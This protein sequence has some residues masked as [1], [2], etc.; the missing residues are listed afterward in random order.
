MP[1]SY[2]PYRQAELDQRAAEEEIKAQRRLNAQQAKQAA[3]ASEAM[4]KEDR[5]AELS[6]QELDMR[7]QG[8]IPVTTADGNLHPDPLW[9]Q[10]QAEKAAK[11]AQ[12]QQAAKIADQFARE[13]RKSFV[14]KVT[15]LPTA[16]ESDEQLAA[17]KQAK[18]DAARK[19]AIN[20]RITALETAASDPA[21]KR[22]PTSARDKLAKQI[23]KTRQEALFGLQSTL[24]EQAK[25]VS[26]GDDY[27]PFN[28]APT[29]EA[30]AA[31]ERLTR[32]SQPGAD[33]TEE[34]LALLEANDATKPQAQKLRN[35][36]ALLAKDDEAAKFHDTQAA[37]VFDLKLR[38][39]DPA[40]WA[41]KVK[42]RRAAMTPEQLKTD[43]ESSSADLQARSQELQAKV[44]PIQ[45]RRALSQQKLDTLS[46]QAAQRR[47]RG[48]MASEIVTFTRPDGSTEDWPADLAATYERESAMAQQAETQ[49]AATLEQLQALQADLQA[50]AAL[51]DEGTATLGAKA[52][53]QQQTA[54]SQFSNR[55]R[56][57]PGME[58]AAGEIEALQSDAETRKAVLDDMYP[59]GAPPEAI[60][61]LNADVQAKAEQAIAT[62]QARLNA[63]TA[64][65]GGIQAQ[66]KANPD[67]NATAGD[68]FIATRKKLAQDAGITEAEAKRLLDDAGQLDWDQVTADEINQGLVAE[69]W[70]SGKNMS[71]AEDSRKTRLLSN[72]AVIVHPNITDEKGY[73]AAVSQSGATPDAQAEAL[74]RYPAIRAQQ[75]KQTLETIQEVQSVLGPDSLT[76]WEDYADWKKKKPTDVDEAEWALRWSEAN[77]AKNTGILGTLLS[78]TKQFIGNIAAGGND[79]RQQASG[80]LAGI[81]GSETLMQDAQWAGRKAEAQGSRLALGGHTSDNFLTKGV[82]DQLPRLSTSLVPAVGGAKAAQAGIRLFAGTKLG[83]RFLPSLAAALETAATPAQAVKAVSTL[84]RAGLGGAAAAGA[85]Q[86][87]GAQ[88]AD[89]YGTLRKENPEL[90]HATA[91]RQAQM[92]AIASGLATALLTVGFGST[93][94]SRLITRPAEAKAAAAKVFTS[95]LQ[96]MGFAAE[97]FVSGGIMET[98]E[99]SLDEGISQVAAALGKG[100]P[101]QQAVG[102]FLR[103]LPEMAVATMIMGGAGEGISSFKESSLQGTAASRA[104]LPETT[105][106][107]ESA[108]DNLQLPGV[109]DAT[110]EQMQ[111]RA[112][113]ALSLAQGG[114]LLEVEESDLNAAGWTRD[115]DTFKPLKGYTGPAVLDIDKGGR[116]IIKDAY[117]Q[118]LRDNGLDAVANAIPGTETQTRNRYA[119][120]GTKNEQP[121]TS[122]APAGPQQ[123]QPS[124]AP[125]TPTPVSGNANPGPV[126][127][128]AINGAQ[129]PP[130]GNPAA[131]SG[132]P[133]T[134]SPTT[135]NNSQP[136]QTS[137][138]DPTAV[139]TLEKSLA[140]WL[141]DRYMPDKEAA[142]AAKALAAHPQIAGKSFDDFNKLAGPQ[143]D[144][145]FAALGITGSKAKTKAAT[146]PL[147]F[148]PTVNNSQPPSTAKPSTSPPTAA[149]FAKAQAAFDDSIEGTPERAAAEA[150]LKYLREKQLVADLAPVKAAVQ[151]KELDEEQATQAAAAALRATSQPVT[152]SALRSALELALGWNTNRANVASHNHLG[153]K[154]QS[155]TPLASGER[156]D[157][158]NRPQATG[159]PDPS[160]ARMGPDL[161]LK[162][163]SALRKNSAYSRAKLL[164]L[165]RIKD[166]AK[167]AWARAAFAALEDSIQRH[168]ALYD[169][170]A[171]GPAAIRRLNGAMTAVAEIDGRITRLLDLNAIVANFDY[172]ANP[173][174]A[175]RAT[176]IEEDI[177]ATV[178]R[179]ART[180]PE[181]YG[182]EAIRKQWRSLPQNLRELVWKAYDYGRTTLPAKLTAQQ[183]YHMQNE[184]LRMLVQ[185]QAFAQAITE[186]VDTPTT[187]VQWITDLLRDLS[188]TLRE[189]M[190]QVDAPLRAELQGMVDQIAAQLRIF[191]KE[192][193]GTADRLATLDYLRDPAGI[194]LQAM[195][196]GVLFDHLAKTDPSLTPEA[197]ARAFDL[198][199]PELQSLAYRAYRA[200][201]N[202]APGTKNKEPKSALLRHLLTA[203]AGD[204]SVSREVQSALLSKSPSLQVSKSAPLLSRFLAR[205]TQRTEAPP[206]DLLTLLKQQPQKARQTLASLNAR[207]IRAAADL[208]GAQFVQSMPG[209]V[210]DVFTA[211]PPERHA[212]MIAALRQAELRAQAE[213]KLLFQSAIPGTVLA[214]LRR[215]AYAAGEAN[216]DLTQSPNA[217]PEAAAELRKRLMQ[218]EIDARRQ[219]ESGL[220]PT[221]QD[222]SDPSDP[223][224][225]TPTR[226]D[227]MAAAL[228][229]RERLA[230][231]NR[232]P[233]ARDALK[234]RLRAQQYTAELL[235]ARSTQELNSLEQQRRLSPQVRRLIDAML[236]AARGDF[237]PSNRKMGSNYKLAGETT[238]MDLAALGIRIQPQTGR[239]YTADPVNTSAYVEQGHVILRQEALDDL[240]VLAPITRQL[241]RMTERQVRQVFDLPVTG[242]EPVTE[243]N[244]AEEEQPE[245]PP[246]ETPPSTPVNAPSEPQPPSTTPDL[247]VSQPSTTVNAA[248]QPQPPSTPKARIPLGGKLSL[249]AQFASQDDLDA[250][251]YQ[252]DRES[253]LRETTSTTDRRKAT[254]RIQS[255]RARLID[256]T[257]ASKE[258]I[259]QRLA[260]YHRAV[261]DSAKKADPVEV[262]RPTPFHAFAGGVS[263]TSDATL[264]APTGGDIISGMKA[265]GIRRLGPPDKSDGWAW[266]RE[267][268]ADASKSKIKAREAA[269][270][271][272]A[273]DLTDSKAL[274]AWVDTHIVK[275]DGGRSIDEAAT[276]LNESEE[277]QFQVASGEE[278]G[279][280]ILDAIAAR[281][282]AR[283]ATPDPMVQAEKQA[284]Q[285]GGDFR[286]VAEGAT[287]QPFTGSTLAARVQT[288]DE[289]QIG[290]EWLTVT[291]VDTEEG[292]VSLDSDRYG[293]QSIDPDQTVHLRAIGDEVLNSQPSPTVNNGQ[294]PSTSPSARLS[295]DTIATLQNALPPGQRD[296]FRP[297][298]IEQTLTPLPQEKLATPA[299]TAALDA[300]LRASV[301]AG[302]A[303]DSSAPQ[304]ADAD[305]NDELGENADDYLDGEA[306]N[307]ALRTT[308]DQRRQSL[309]GASVKLGEKSVRTGEPVTFRF[310]HNLQSATKIWGKPTKDSQFD[311]GFEPSGRYVSETTDPDYLLKTFPGQYAAGELTFEN[312]IVIDGGEYGSDTS[313]KRRLSTLYGGTRGKRLSQALLTDGYDG[314]ITVSNG[315]TSEILDLTTFDAS[316]ALYASNRLAPNGKPSN[317]TEAQWHQVRTPQFKKWFGDWEIAA[318]NP[319]RN[320]ST[321]SEA[322]E[323]VKEFQGKPLSNRKTG[324][325]ATLSRNALDKILSA[326]AVGK[327]ETAQT[328]SL[329][330]ANADV[331]FESAILGWSKPD[332]NADPNI[333][334]IHRFFA[335]MITNGK[336]M[337]VKMTVKETSQ[338]GR[339][340]PL[341]TVEAVEFNEMSPAAIWVGEIANA[342]GIDPRT[343]R[344]VGDLE[345]LTQE[346]QDFNPDSVSKVVDENGEPMVVYHGTHRDFDQFKGNAYYFSANPKTASTFA[347]IRS[348]GRG[349]ENVMPVFLSLKSPVQEDMDGASWQEMEDRL[350]RAFSKGDSAIFENV[351]DS[352]GDETQYIAFDPTQIKSAVANNGDFDGTNPSILF[353]SKR[354]KDALP[355]PRLTALHN[356]SIENL[357]FA[358]RMGGL[359]VPSVAV[360]PQGQGISGF[361][362][363]TLIGTR[364]LVDPAKEPVFDSDAYSPRFPDAEYSKAK[365]KEAQA[366]VD[367]LRPFATRFDD[368]SLIHT[369]WDNAVNRPN[370]ADS[371]TKLLRSDAAKASFLASKGV[372]IEPVLMPKPLS[373]S[374]VTQ[375]SF[376]KYR[377]N[378]AL[379]TQVS[380]NDKQALDAIG[381]DIKAAINEELAAKHQ[382]TDKPTRDFIRKSYLETYLDED[383]G[384]SNYGRLQ[385]VEISLQ[386]VGKQ[387]VDSTATGERITAAMAGQDAEFKQWADD[388]ILPLHPAPHLTLKGRKAPYTL[389]NIVSAM[390][391]RVRGREDGMTMGEGKA[392]AQI[393]KKFNDL[394][395]MRAAAAVQ[396]LPKEQVSADREK[397]QKLLETY[398]NT[399]AEFTTLT[400][401]RGAKDYFAAFDAAMAALVTWAKGR[402]DVATLESAL[403][404]EGFKDVPKDA[405]ALGQQA[406]EAWL[407]APVPYFEAKPQRAVA[408]SEFA[409]AVIPESAPSGVKTI[410]DKHGILHRAYSG[411]SANQASAAAQFAQDLNDQ[412]LG[413]LFASGRTPIL[414]ASRD[415]TA[416]RTAKD[417]WTA[418]GFPRS[419]ADD[420]VD[421]FY[422][423]AAFADIPSNAVLL[424]MPS[425]SGRNIL[426]DVLAQRIA[427]QQGATV[428]TGRV[429]SATARTEAKKKTSFWAKMDDP[430]GYIPGPDFDALRRATGPI[431]LV[432]DVHN[433]GESWMAM[434]R[435]L[436]DNGIP[437]AGVATLTATELRVTSPRDIERLSEKIATL[438][439]TPLDKT[440]ELVY[441]LFHDSY[442]QWFN[443]AERIATGDAGQ[444]VRLL[445]AARA[446]A[447]ERATQRN[448]EAANEGRVQ[449]QGNQDALAP[450]YE[451]L[452]LFASSRLKESA[453][454]GYLDLPNV[455]VPAAK[456]PTAKRAI[457]AAAASTDPYDLPASRGDVDRSRRLDTLRERAQRTWRGLMNQDVDALKEAF[458]EKD[459]FSTLLHDFI[460]R[461]IPRFDIR[462]AIIEG[463]A[464]FAAFN[465]AV[466]TPYFESLK[467]AI[468]DAANQVVHSQIVHVGGLNEAIADPKVIAGIIA[469]ARMLNPKSKLTGWMIAHNHPSGDP[470]PSDAD[471]RVTRRLLAMGENIGLPLIDHVVTNGERYFSFRESGL[472]FSSIDDSIAQ[473]PTRSSKPK[474]PA[475]PTPTAPFQDNLA[476]YE[477]LPSGSLKTSI[478]LNAPDKTRPYLQTLRT[479]DPDHYHVLY[480]DTRLALRAVERIPTSVTLPQLFQRIVLGSAREGGHAF[481]L[482]FPATLETPNVVQEDQ[483]NAAAPSPQQRQIVRRLRELSQSIGLVFADAMTHSQERHFSFSEYGLMEEPGALASGPRRAR[484]SMTFDPPFKAPFGDILSYSWASKPIGGMQSQRVSDWNNAITN[485]QTGRDIVHLFKVRKPDGIHTVSLETALGLLSSQDRNRL[486]SIIRSKQ[487][488]MED[489]NAG[490]MRLFA[491]S[492]LPIAPQLD[493]RYTNTDGQDS[494]E[495]R[496]NS[497]PLADNLS[498]GSSPDRSDA[499]RLPS[500][501]VQL[502]AW[503]KT[504]GWLIDTDDLDQRLGL[505]TEVRAGDEHDVW[506]DELTNRAVKLTRHTLGQPVFIA[507]SPI[508]YIVNLKQQNA[509]FGTD[510][511]F[512]G[513]VSDEGIPRIV[514]SMPW[515]YGTPVTQQAK[516]KY[517]KALGF[518][519][520]GDDTFYSMGRD[521]LVTDARAANVVERP[522]GTIQPIDIQIRAVSP[523]QAEMWENRVNARASLPAA[524]RV[525]QAA[526]QTNANPSDAQKAAGNYQK[527]KINL[528]GLRLSIENPAGSVR[529]GTDA[530][531]KP[532]SVTLPH[533]YGYILGT[534][535]K[536][537][538]H[539]DIFLGPNPDSQQVLIINQRKSGNGHFDEHKVMLGFNTPAEAA[540]GYMA[541]YT[542]GWKGLGSAIPTTIPVF[543][544]WLEKHD[545]TQP[546]TKEQID[547]LADALPASKRQPDTSITNPSDA[548]FV[549]ARVAEW[550][551]AVAKA[552]AA[553]L[554]AIDLRKKRE[555]ADE[556]FFKAPPEEK[557]ARRTEAMQLSDAEWEAKK[558]ADRFP[559]S[560]QGL[561]IRFGI[562]PASGRSQNF[563]TST[564]DR[565]RY[566]K[567]I[568]TFPVTWENGRWQ[569]AT[570]Y[571][572]AP[573]LDALIGRHDRHIYLVTGTVVDEGEDN[574]PVLGSDYRVLKE[575]TPTEILPPDYGNDPTE[576]D[577]SD[578]AQNWQTLFAAPRVETAARALDK[579]VTG[580][581][582]AIPTTIPVFKQ[583]LE[584][585]DT[586]QPATKEQIDK[587]S[588]SVPLA[589]AFRNKP[590]E[591]QSKNGIGSSD[592]LSRRPT[593]DTRADNAHSVE[594]IA[595]IVL[596]ADRRANAGQ[597][598]VEALQGNRD[599]IAREYRTLIDWA[600]KQG[601]I[602][603]PTKL[604]PERD[605]R[606]EHKVYRSADTKLERLYKVTYP[607]LSGLTRHALRLKN[608]SLRLMEDD[609]LP[610][611]YLDRWA[612]HNEMLDDDT[613]F[614]GIL[615]SIAGPSI[616][617][618]QPYIHGGH[619]DTSPDLTQAGWLQNQNYWSK[620]HPKEPGL[621]IGLADTKP[622]NWIQDSQTKAVLSIDTIPF[623]IP[624]SILPAS[625]RVETAARALDKTV[626]GLGKAANLI[627]QTVGRTL[628]AVTGTGQFIPGHQA[629]AKLGTQLGELDAAAAAEAGNAIAKGFL[630]V[631]GKDIRKAPDAVAAWLNQPAGL[632]AWTK[633]VVVDQL[634]PTAM[635]PREWLALSH[636]MQR[637]TAFGA[638]KSNDL[639][640][641]LSGNPRLSDLAYPKEFAENPAYREQLF[642]AME[643]KIPMSSLPP[644]MQ[645]LGTRL[646]Q[647]LRDT[648][649]ELVRQGIMHPDTF[650][651]L[652]ATGWMPRYMLDE[653][654]ESGGSVLAA[655]KLGVKDLM[656]QRTTAFH[657]VDTSRKGKDGQH[658]TVNRQEGGRNAWRFRDAATRDAFYSDFI[659]RQA[660]DMLQDRHGND[661]AMQAMFA[662]LDH[663]QRREVRRQIGMLTRAD[664]DTPQKLS[665]ALAGMVKAAIEHQKAKYKKENPFDPPK[666]IKDPV[667]AIARYVLA[668]THNA[669]T[670]ELLNETAKNKEWVSDVSLQ[671]YTEIPDNDRFGP[672]AGKFVQKDIAAQILDKMDV[673][674]AALRFYD[675]IL[676]K[677]KSG[678]L[679]WNPGSHIR[680][681][682]GNTV[683]AYLG[684]SSI[685][686]PGNWPYYRQALEVMRN[687]GPIYAELIEHGVL[688]GDAYSSLVRERLKGLLPDAATAENFNP[689]LI[690]RFFFDFGAKFHATHEQLA[691]YRRVPDDFYKIAAYL[692]AKDTISQQSPTIANDRQQLQTMAAGHVRKWFPYYDRL[693]GSSTT[694]AVGRFVNPFFSFFRESTRILGTAAKERPIALS[695][696]LAF[697][698][699][700]SALSAM[701]LGL[702][703]DDRDEIAKDLSGRGKGI[704]GLGG[705]HLFSMLL[706]VRSGSGQV[707]QFDISAIMPFADL[708][709]QKIVPLEEKENAWQTFWR[710]TAAAGPV[711][712]LAVS[713]ITNRDTFSGR[714][715][716][717]AD[718]STRELLGAYTQHAAGVALPP[719]LPDAAAAVGIGDGGA[720]TRAGTRQV[721][722]TLATYDP[723]QTIIRSVFGMNVK[724]A[725]P[726]LYRQ[727]DDFRAANGY[728]AQPGFDYG[729]TVTSRAKRLLVAQLAQ[730]EPNPAAIK[731]LVRRLKELGVPM[732]TEGDINKT[733]SII[734]PA[735]LIGGSKKQNLSAETARQRFRQSLPPESRTIYEAALSEYQ[736]IKQRAPLLVRQAAS[737]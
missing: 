248:Q 604:G 66:L 537:G 517:F 353:A 336:A 732:D 618:S 361:G 637:K 335:P 374:F 666:L 51:H 644:A 68:L 455:A 22:L 246:A 500:E 680:D 140:D 157:T 215:I 253:L 536:D 13:G 41:A 498:D 673:P 302:N 630:R 299:D 707:Q 217:T 510:Y 449:G 77:K 89:I 130:S 284:V 358:D 282:T 44:A 164:A 714:H 595:R 544:Q 728:D 626:T 540:R 322:R 268:K 730:D 448:N 175:I 242:P 396:I 177:H 129:P 486:T 314:V 75:A 640:R 648:G 15:G 43:L 298:A 414:T 484:E 378:P 105:A 581:G 558:K 444:A 5:K 602:F 440:T 340:N 489:E 543:K 385:R 132:P 675:A 269:R 704:L 721:N 153:T 114:E 616:V 708:L 197:M 93:G 39:D 530:N 330:V 69:S 357:V 458:T 639:I 127:A 206:A 636:E 163:K 607:G 534:E 23:D 80:I 136:P 436:E 128:P 693:G 611:E 94:I 576:W 572:S 652:Q 21:K 466:R 718:M 624:T 520:A 54:K 280:A 230:E 722:K 303:L 201:N 365:S 91:L 138:S 348:G 686:N 150:Q 706:P 362:G 109:D 187:L 447:R 118:S 218:A 296:I 562:P 526:A 403:R 111:R 143:R 291:D 401:Y 352:L 509:L 613:R 709:G 586:T 516:E 273:G 82:F 263:D 190:G 173:A 411:P 112:A 398:R 573:S 676:R 316:K 65:Y 346:I 522:D 377:E 491:S 99:E 249:P 137:P 326:S 552:D 7:A 427:E 419:M 592:D 32:L 577:Q 359:A 569:F 220:L 113:V 417:A 147:R 355:Q 122:P 186:T 101:V 524:A 413:T 148:N 387:Q 428:Q 585:Q 92:P 426:P 182:P 195:Q 135:A 311:R 667:Y 49:E 159:G 62:G 86:T 705:L 422:K 557:D 131:Q 14:S 106:L 431:Y 678:K 70:K 625:P 96:R 442:K 397:A 490:Q 664:L 655:F 649:T 180:Q 267:L 380:A 370:P 231:Q 305:L 528:H 241:V 250:F 464:D 133:V 274:L 617:I 25:A 338:K 477:A 682:V 196:S 205:L 438:T 591:N 459:S 255:V 115:G 478:F 685:M 356:L 90:D 425:T 504:Q 603:D 556:A 412:G 350:E 275:Q 155:A 292:T 531:G 52:Q 293:P 202:K 465:L 679:V 236:K 224:E 226:A 254:D 501:A 324:I 662:P 420:I 83:A 511:A 482:G 684:G 435:L 523:G 347:E 539:V 294:P 222:L 432:E 171:I 194:A 124:P 265:Q 656:Q 53:E 476:D 601:L 584:K 549:R 451:Q 320:A 627:P 184:F 64:A 223:A 668:Q 575:L 502:L 26:G 702:D 434:R 363:I 699:A 735:A 285:Q 321:F 724:S 19:T 176:G 107:A 697:P 110:R 608:G 513:I 156:T 142:A 665:S 210:Q 29:P 212:D 405:L 621:I 211:A 78:K 698:A 227:D 631:S 622:S 437:V 615:E 286:A 71:Q 661:K 47:Q 505:M 559:R 391:G 600:R 301:D 415:V 375:P 61:A 295:P 84:T 116:P 38:R 454:Q 198:L 701:L 37:S 719:L 596:G 619:P 225:P 17:Q 416:L 514:I 712:N 317:L 28:E 214:E 104:N 258:D 474:L 79:L 553:A 560:I 614:E 386:N 551:D 729:T 424:P 670:M 418:A 16:L 172:L 598:P 189:L 277:Q 571:G 167:K 58:Q 497:H 696:A 276:E 687:G 332:K 315:H 433:T 726:N 266:Y 1:S 672:L 651:E 561:Y 67:L 260:D 373:A 574:E 235:R 108:I 45:Q 239:L 259:E 487:K 518:E 160:A 371:I 494:P 10:K 717:E 468:L 76:D 429:A 671:G 399:V 237:E 272:K 446:H 443:K 545:T 475:L 364:D 199:T 152:H 372:Q 471:R 529:S 229:D 139:P 169:A 281:Q 369:V 731:N 328:H 694:R 716:T 287:G 646:R 450:S 633:T 31:Q 583:W 221:T 304:I 650:E 208:A 588:Q 271:A 657:I 410:L 594:F 251:Q 191:E 564:P 406:A 103:T 234:R 149:D 213:G 690:Q 174:D 725:A 703:D 162:S 125:A 165:A 8:M 480:L 307:A 555:I 289:I 50:E 367:K 638:E 393:S 408:L 688:G 334:A 507:G 308:P 605:A 407:N 547:K 200:S 460:S 204:A 56:F 329:A 306:L 647:M 579:T 565:P 4:V 166:P 720:L 628:A 312:P 472:I 290:S 597:S 483:S 72:G 689:G 643:N 243:A 734:D 439:D 695:A 567:G 593:S 519:P 700:I 309:T 463:P 496:R 488:A 400:N 376:A 495:A 256:E 178:L 240:D 95:Q 423:P 409:G 252:L 366:L 323:A 63:A 123:S 563:I 238:E 658:P 582:S 262:F 642:D 40:A 550:Q 660:L 590:I 390:T 34:D 192:S 691:E 525:A 533:H 73:A 158:A 351:R 623:V 297:S 117:I 715:L 736:R 300:D 568:S 733:L 632:G 379:I 185:D 653:A 683:F 521:L 207:L 546:A 360:T 245:S 87:Y 42:E 395:K 33:L 566:E 20:E 609:A 663:S 461:E 264:P 711:G 606:G 445:D 74:A 493:L 345:T 203:M 6:R 674:N 548:A 342:D 542:K 515:V 587:L 389:E 11:A 270:L 499:R 629:L 503:A 481:T 441:G 179:L 141:V 261:I 97:A 102:D 645:A 144:A 473:R 492:R 183:E 9:E 368:S 388:L 57:T 620:P 209:A 635:M 578:E 692:K 59:D 310:I 331:L 161:S 319:K 126:Q 279:R 3:K 710:Q 119:Q 641:A 541:S 325:E 384:S 60:D 485:G 154:D 452:S 383:T 18:A 318:S 527:G 168:H 30:T 713:W 216:A 580:L 35:I 337:M 327:S 538:D 313:W 120:Q 506:H 469:T 278:L 392:R 193:Q 402:R 146:D 462:G 421:R 288:G 589:A 612:L 98:I 283:D 188:K 381:R 55:L 659:R 46:Q 532:W 333:V 81:T 88:L 599:D 233:Q 257:G 121:G 247:P 727:A 85:G 349:G 554:E 2:D 669:A 36:Q 737:L 677:W 508:T 145:L 219:R 244:A 430:V 151:A 681:A 27:I 48:L 535:G 232:S 170:I 228:D 470:S 100:H 512:E 479:A 134:P 394:E 339:N 634:L 654:M 610:S 467:I 453:I 343:T 457:R 382:D 181:K 344:S 12:E 24:Q 456:Q 723:V 404:R 341:Y 354:K 570:S